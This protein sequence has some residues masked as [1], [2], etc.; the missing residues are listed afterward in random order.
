MVFFRNLNFEPTPKSQLAPKSPKGDFN[1]LF[2]YSDSPVGAR[3]KKIKI[4]SFLTF[5]SGLN[6]A[7]FAVLLFLVAANTIDAAEPASDVI[8]VKGDHFYPPFEF[9]NEKGEPDGFNVELFKKIASDL[10]LNYTLELG[11][12]EKV[13]KELENNEIDLLMGVLVSDARKDKLT[14]GLT[15]SMMNFDIFTH[16]D[17][18][19][20]SLDELRG[21]KVVVQEE[22]YMHDYLRL[23]NI[24][25]QLI[26]TKDQLEALKLVNQ[27]KCDAAVLGNY[28]AA[29][30]IKKFDLQQVKPMEANISSVPYAMA[31]RNGNDR[32]IWML[33]AALYNL[34]ENGYYDQLYEKW[35]TVYEKRDYL[36]AYYFEIFFFAGLLILAMLLIIVLRKRVGVIAK[37]LKKS[38]EG[39]RIL[40]ANQQDFILKLIPKEGIVSFVSPSFCKLLAKD[41][42]DLIDVALDQLFGKDI[43]EAFEAE[44]AKISEKES[45]SELALEMLIEGRPY[46]INWR[47]SGIFSTTGQLLEVMVVGRDVTKNKQYE[48]V[49]LDSENRFRQLLET[50]PNIAVQ[51]CRADG[52]VRYWNSASETLY[53]YSS[54]EAIDRTL[55]ELIIPD[56]LSHSFRQG[57]KQALE[58]ET[59]IPPSEIELRHK[60]GTSVWV[61]SSSTVINFP[62]G[63]K[64]L[65]R[66]DVNLSEIKRSQL[67]QQVLFN[68]TNAVHINSNLESLIQTIH[69]ELSKLMDCS[70]L[71]I[72]FYNAEKD[73]LSTY[74]QNDEVEN[75]PV[76]P[77]EG[78]LSGLVVR[79]RKSLLVTSHDFK[80]LEQQGLVKLVGKPAA[81]WLGVP[82]LAGEEVLGAVVVQSFEHDDAYDQRTVELM[83][84]VS[85]QIGLAI[86][87]QRNLTNLIQAKRKAE[88]SDKLKTAFLNNLSHEIRTPLNAIVGLTALYDDAETDADERRIYKEVIANNSSQ[89]TTIID[90]IIH[91]SAIETEQVEMHIGE[92][93]IYQL[94]DEIAG[95]YM[96]RYQRNDLQL[97]TD[98]PPEELSPLIHSDEGKLRK[99]IYVLLDNAFKFTEK[100]QIS[101]RWRI[102]ADQLFISVEDTGIGIEL[103][104]QKRIFERF[105]KIESK[106]KLYRGNG[107]G[108]AIAK[109]Y[110]DVLD[111]RISVASE[112]QKGALFSV[113]IPVKTTSNPPKNTIMNHETSAGKMKIKI[114]VVEDELS[115]L[116][117]IKSSLKDEKYDLTT[118]NNGSE[119]VSVFEKHPD[120]D[121]ILMDLKLPLLNGYDATRQIKTIRQDVPIIAITAYALRGDKEKALEAGCDAYLAKPFLKEELISL[122]SK[123]VPM[124]T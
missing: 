100:G 63:H 114:L 72:A 86:Q 62:D 45:G 85:R 103:Q 28:Q 91:M 35:F 3:I 5:R 73:E 89:L 61:Y 20:T 31:V 6:F 82:L 12:W 40:I 92:I 33:N 14:Y 4:S 2:V 38:E 98:F 83:E 24:T 88:Q 108:L 30:L 43:S 115:N 9:I 119:A 44:I 74:D 13:R 34:K 57:F 21:K 76:W 29:Y 67:V 77:A 32:L 116:H 113:V 22:D 53:G 95:T 60:N 110:S 101:L 36:K 122:I 54:T 81:V 96:V 99:I 10:N 69:Y 66:V 49:L 39:Y 117:F 97:I 78:S 50:I 94:M 41:E 25:D 15:H 65:F 102:E 59:V 17:H 87:R 26:Y 68:I 7:V 37:H 18:S 27:G 90:D 1:E 19:F 84:F 64:E 120:F 106:K 47:F 56:H 93:N 123:Q 80:K 58:N 112:P 121:I 8:R 105:Q 124:P 48:Q 118:T 51:G 46:W 52:R 23:M 104:E 79:Q 107:L 55:F 11:P 42:A 16:S 75:I 109:G 70:N 71:F 111:A